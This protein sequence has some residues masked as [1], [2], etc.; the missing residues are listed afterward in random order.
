MIAIEIYRIRIGLNYSRQAKVKGIKHLNYFEMLIIMSLL[1][2]AGVERN[3]GPASES[4]VGST[5]NLTNK[6]SIVHYNVQSLANKL[7]LIESEFRHF[8]VICI[9]E[10]WL[11]DRTSDED[12]RIDNFKLFRRDRPGD[13]HG[14]IC[15]YIRSNV[16]SKR[17]DDLELPNIECIWIEVSISNKKQLIGTF[18]RPPNSPNAVLSSFEDSIGL[19]FDSNIQNILLTGDFNLDTLKETSYRKIIDLCRQFNLE[20]LINEP[21]HFTENSSSVIDLI[22]TSNKNTVILSG[23]GEPFLE[24]NIRYHCPTYCVLNFTKP[25]TPCFKRKIYLFDRGNYQTFSNDLIDTD[26]N[27]LKSNDIDTYAEN[28]TNRITSLTNKHIPNK[29]I[30]VRQSDPS[31]LTNNIK[32][33]LRKKKRLYDKYKKSKNPNH[34][35]TYKRFRNHVTSEL[36]KS[37]Q[38]QIDKLSEKLVNPDTGQKD[39]WKTLKG[40][41]KPDQTNTLPPLSKDG[42]IYSNDSDKASILNDFFRD[43][44][45]LDESRATLPQTK[46]LPTYKIESIITT[47]EEVE[48]T[49]KSL[50]LGKA[51]GPD[52]INNRILKNL[53]HPLS[54]PFC[55]LFNFS[56]NQGLVPKLW[57]QAN[58]S[59]I[60]KKNDPSDVSN[61]R[62][63]SLLSTVGKVL[64]KIV[65]KH[66]FNFL[67]EHHVITTLQSGFVPGD[68]TVNQLVDIY[69]T[70][71]KALDE[72]KEVRA[73]FCDISKAFDRVWHKGLLYKLETKGVSGSLLSWFTDY[74][75]GRLQRVVLP[76]GSSAWTPIKAGVPQ[77]SILGPIMFLLYIND[78]VE[79]IDSSIRLFADD[80]SLYIVVDDP[81]Q[82]AESLNS[83][84]EKVS[85]WAKQWLVTFNPAKSESILFSRKVNK[86]YHPPVLMDQT[87]INEVS[88]HKHLGIIF[89]ND[90]SWHDHIEHIKTKAWARINVMR[91]LKFKLDRKSLQ[92]IYFSFIRPLLEYADIVWNNC[93]QYESNELEKIQN[94]AARIVTGATKLASI[95]SLL[96]ETGWE[97]LSSRRNKHKI[98]FFYK[99]KNDLSPDYLC[100]L[101]PPTIGSTSSY[102]LRNANNLRILHTH[103]QLYYN[104]FLPSAVREWNDLPEPTRN[105]PSLNIFKSRINSNITLPP[106]YYS[107]GKR[108]GQIYH[109]RLRTKCSS[110]R[111]HLFS[112]NI[113]DSPRCE[114]G[115]VEDNHHF[116]LVCNKYTDLRRELFTIV[117]EKCQPTLNV[118][119]YGDLSLSF[120]ENKAIVLAVHD[121]ILKSKRF[122]R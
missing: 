3:P 60:H 21:T 55:D 74:L 63:I 84:L 71:C 112:K 92:T 64:E 35:D 79:N 32:K 67:N 70:F 61:Y 7:D 14:G 6:F 15:V 13:H 114:C 68:S 18:Y 16:Y 49:L 117:S 5:S 73:I 118:L 108:I 24:Q 59:P 41:I 105:S 120:E 80:T 42:T 88:S 20:Q 87:Q 98:T 110:L 1:L 34:W 77:G 22:L 102:P 104:S 116:L 29:L 53:A 86:P 33:L 107:T 27:T 99:M 30:K 109:A 91:K 106:S 50:P 111:Q 25:T 115:S 4:S 95:D 85:R 57:K 97:T 26:W 62:P 69:N 39:W 82:A 56:L 8:D 54:F 101:V 44:T 119:L 9:S 52:L 28:I 36:R 83:D 76:G 90:C 31:W 100:S 10:T 19:A 122:Q 37:K 75:N 96:L 113:S 81:I 94:E 89:S 78:I 65:H 11:D 103:S 66:L 47:P 48:S 72:G 40:F 38:N 45:L 93:A 58:V 12:I 23:V 17:R 46:P 51:T 43:Q 2:I 121:F